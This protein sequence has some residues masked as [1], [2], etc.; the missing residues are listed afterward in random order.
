MPRMT[1]LT[2]D[3]KQ[4]F[5]SPPIF[6]SVER[7]RFFQL[8]ESTSILDTLRSPTNEV[9]FVVTL[10]YFKAT[11]RF[12]GR[13]FRDEDVDYVARKL[14]FLSELIDTDSYDEA[15]YRRHQKLVRD[16]LGFWR[17]DEAAKQCIAREVRTMVRSQS[18]TSFPPEEPCYAT[19]HT[20]NRGVHECHG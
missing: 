17:F 16:R 15:T 5:D 13:H 7:K 6:S 10:G 3:E 1:I 9:C 19:A 14:G 2:A 11:K 12:F 4:V 8:T 18:K 20:R